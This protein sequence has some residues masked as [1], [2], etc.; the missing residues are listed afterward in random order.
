MLMIAVR[1][2]IVRIG[3]KPNAAEKPSRSPSK[4]AGARTLPN[5]RRHLQE[6]QGGEHGDEAERIEEEAGAG[7]RCIAKMKPASDGPTSRARLK[8]D[9]L[10]AIALR[11][12]LPIGEHRRHDRL[13]GRNVDDVGDAED[14]VQEKELPELRLPRHDERGQDERLHH[15]HRLH[16]DEEPMAIDV[17]DEQSGERGEQECRD[18]AGEVDASGPGGGGV[19]HLDDEPAQARRSGSRCR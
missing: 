3:A 10:R 7:S 18:L 19:G 6:R 12:V 13:P 11:E 16:E 5:Q 15:H 14:E 8:T 17:I 2:I 1:I 4:M 9:E